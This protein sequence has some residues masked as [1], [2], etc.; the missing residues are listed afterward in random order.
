MLSQVD[1]TQYCEISRGNCHWSGQ[2]AELLT[3]KAK[4]RIKGPVYSPAICI[5]DAT[6]S[7]LKTQAQSRKSSQRSWSSE[8]DRKVFQLKSTLNH[9]HSKGY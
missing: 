9:T 4:W 2:R 6:A 7:T 3:R 5:L 1:A 8:M